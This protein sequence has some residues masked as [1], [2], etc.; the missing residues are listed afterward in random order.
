MGAAVV[1]LVPVEPV[2][3]FDPGAGGVVD[4]PVLFDEG[5][6]LPGI[7]GLPCIVDPGRGGCLPLA[8]GFFE[9]LVGPATGFTTRNLGLYCTHPRCGPF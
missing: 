9:F 4:L 6:V 7:G 1:P 2:L 3:G 5:R 8:L